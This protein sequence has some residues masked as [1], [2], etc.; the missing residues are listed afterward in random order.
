MVLEP[1]FLKYF[2]LLRFDIND[3]LIVSHY[4]LPSTNNGYVS[5]IWST[6]FDAM[7]KVHS[8]TETV[9]HLLLFFSYMEYIYS[10]LYLP[11]S[12]PDHS[13]LVVALVEGA[14]QLTAWQRYPTSK[15]NHIVDIGIS[16]IS[17]HQ[18]VTTDASKLPNSQPNIWFWI[19]IIWCMS[20]A[21]CCIVLLESH[22]LPCTLELY[23]G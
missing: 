12:L 8:R 22:L 14:K 15:K 19:Y 5:L 11:F 9:D 4:E 17:L 10:G 13:C 20:N 16:S 7:Q 23:Q 3:K 6:K 18:L 1:P 2:A 21:L